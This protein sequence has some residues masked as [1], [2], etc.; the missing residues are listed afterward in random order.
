MTDFDFQ[1]DNF[2]LYCSSKNLSRKT[3]ASYEQTLK[4]LGMYLRETYQI[5]EVKKVQSGHIRQY[6]KY[7]RERGKYTVVNKPESKEKNYP[8]QRTDYKK[9][10]S[11]TT[12]A[13]YVR[14]I[15]VFFNYLYEVERE[16]SKNP[17]ESIENPKVERKVKKTLTTEEIKKVLG[18]FD[19]AA[20]HGYRNYVITRLLLDTG[21]RIGECLSL[22]PENFDFKHKSILIKNPKNGQERYVYF[23]FKS[24]NEIKSWMRYKDRYSDS[25][26]LF[27]TTRGTQLEIRNFEHALR[28]AGRKVSISIHPH[29]LRNNF[30]KYYILNNGDWFSLCRIL[31]HS[32]VEVTQKAYL[33]FTDEEIGRKYQKHSPLAHLEV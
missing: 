5:E 28:E 16:I 30:A 10:I 33:D 1:L 20:F 25:P 7:L 17:V 29:Q 27:P 31:G 13:N 2:M 23:S 9:D 6:I 8:E 15:K 3:L 11:M 14:N 26:F 24:A 22:Q 21:M 18:Q 4:L 32:S 12:I 19:T